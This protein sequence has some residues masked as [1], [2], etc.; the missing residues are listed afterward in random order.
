MRK[1][2]TGQL[3]LIDLPSVC[4]GDG[5]LGRDHARGDAVAAERLRRERQSAVNVE[6]CQALLDLIARVP[7]AGTAVPA[8][9]PSSR[10][11][12]RAHVEERRVRQLAELYAAFERAQASRERAAAPAAGDDRRSR[13]RGSRVA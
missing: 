7:P 8:A 11:R 13:G 6:Q 3:A 4:P 10:P 5:H 2:S 12:R 9:R 1:T